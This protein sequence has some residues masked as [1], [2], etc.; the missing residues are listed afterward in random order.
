MSHT[1]HIPVL[2]LAY[3]I[4]TPLKVARYGISSVVSIVDDELIERMREYHCKQNGLEYTPIRKSEHDSRARRITAYLNLLNQLV[5]DQFSKLKT[6][7]FEAGNDIERYFNLLP[8]HS[9][10]KQ[11]YDLLDECKEN[12]ERK[13]FEQ[14][15]KNRLIKGS[16][17][18]NIMAKVDKLNYNSHGKYSGDENTDALAALRG[19]AE[20][21]LESSVIIS[22]G[23]NPKL[24]S[25]LE[26][27]DDFYPDENG[28]IRKKVILKVSNY[29]S[30]I[31]Q[32]KVF[33]KKGI[34]VSEF[35]IESGLNCGG[36]AFATDG[37]LLGPI[38][39][40]FKACR[41]AMK[42]ELYE[43]FRAALAA[44]GREVP[45]VP[46]QKISAQGG[47]GTAD[48]DNFLR[49]YY[50]LDSTGWGSP[51]LLVPEATNVDK[52]T[53]EQM[54]NAGRDDFYLSNASPLGVLFNNFKGS[55]IEKQRLIRIAKN[56]PGSPCTKKYLTSNTEFTKQPI[57][58]A[59]R[60]YQR[61][62]I[63]QL[64]D[65]QLSE[66]EYRREF[67]KITEKVCLC[68]GLA[69]SVYIKNDMLKPR[70][71]ASVSICPGPNLAYFSKICSL[72]EMIGHIYGK[73]DVLNKLSNRSNIFVNEL[74]LY[75]D[76]LAKEI[77][78]SKL[79]ITEKKTK[80]LESFKQ[81]L[82]Q[83]ID[84]YR[85]LLP[86]MKS[87]GI[88]YCEKVLKDLSVSELNLDGLI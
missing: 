62:K 31:I 66:A 41:S 74:N 26:S 86:R 44:K 7:P 5:N 65:R 73:N 68:E 48:E 6:E 79:T 18:V 34:W 69:A 81:Q 2:G 24:F 15:L 51:F 52:D 35:R 72:D 42:T 83:G 9:V 54:A 45:E 8:E 25:Y 46:Q 28:N 53:L 12:D 78:N 82:K 77:A 76:Y 87:F 27:F 49:R 85:E 36:H 1:F 13:L 39:E 16:I 71:N 33:A 10:L 11:G 63:I 19:F 30:A 80:Y 37:L 59:S 3:S 70:E 20:S 29:R 60:E 64:D 88:D 21:D 75:I 22:A 4:D 32:A 43:I 58:T 84:Y 50:Q 23:M 55:S 38:L 14:I 40:E 57:C 17:D 67:E 56:R 61:L 47:I